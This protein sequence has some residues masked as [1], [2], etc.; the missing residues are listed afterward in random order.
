MFNIQWE[1][2]QEINVIRY[3]L[4]CSNDGVHYFK[5]GEMNP[6]KRNQ[7][8]Y[9]LNYEDA[10]GNKTYFRIKIIESD[11][12]FIYSNTLN[13]ASVCN[14]GF[15]LNIAPN[16]VETIMSISL[17]MPSKGIATI[18]LLNNIGQVLRKENKLLLRGKNSWNWSG[19]NTLSSG[20]YMLR[21]QNEY[22]QI[23]TRKFIKK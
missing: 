19:I 20:T 6:F 22:G 17:Q 16:P 11:G 15:A 3:E 10:S 1:T 13:I 8:I 2:A 12:S 23:I 7:N 4:E 14:P 21:V 5:I 18:S 9:Q